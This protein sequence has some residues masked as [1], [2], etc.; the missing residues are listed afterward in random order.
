MPEEQ[1]GVSESG[2]KMFGDG[3]I[4]SFE[5]VSDMT[6]DDP[7]SFTAYRGFYILESEARKLNAEDEVPFIK[8]TFYPIILFA[9]LIMKRFLHLSNTVAGRSTTRPSG[10]IF[11]VTTSASYRFYPLLLVGKK[12]SGRISILCTQ[13]ARRRMER[14]GLDNS[15]WRIVPYSK[16]FGFI[17]ITMMAQSVYRALRITR[18]MATH[19]EIKSLR[20]QS[21]VFNL[22][23]TELAK[24]AGF[25]AASSDVESCHFHSPSP[26]I[27][28]NV[29]GHRLYLY[30]HG[31]QIS[32]TERIPAMGVSLT[33]FSWG[34]GWRPER[35]CSSRALESIEFIPAGNPFFDVLIQRREER[36]DVPTNDLIFLSNSHSFST[37][38]LEVYRDIIKRII[39]ICQDNGLTLGIKLHRPQEDISFYKKNRWDHYVTDSDIVDAILSSQVTASDASSGFIESVVLGSP[40]I[41]TQRINQIA[42]QELPRRIPG[43]YCPENLE[44][45]EGVLTRAL[46]TRISVEELNE[47]GV[48]RLGGSADRIAQHIQKGEPHQENGRR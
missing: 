19:L 44:D 31:Q 35:F 22:V 38:Q 29:S 40:S 14:E 43:V 11:V 17:S 4:Y 6:K 45:L 3:P 8:S 39:T 30:Q 37:Q 32:M 23:L 26:Y 13:P 2:P 1:S 20:K 48:F 10:N 34:P 9:Y 47:S 18:Q 21:I 28:K 24:S 7:I 5:N 12:M 27:L 42:D 36:P 16:I 46:N 15:S 25:D 33:Y 41:L